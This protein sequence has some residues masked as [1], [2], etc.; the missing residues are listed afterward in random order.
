MAEQSS[1]KIVGPAVERRERSGFKE[2]GG[3]VV[4]AVKLDVIEF[5]GDAKP[6]G[7]GGGLNAAHTGHG[8]E[9]NVAKAERPADEND[10]QLDGGAKSELLGAKEIDA[11]GADVAS[12]ESDGMGFGYSSGGAKAKGKIQGSARIF[13]LLGMNTHGVGGHPGEATRKSGNGKRR[14]TQ[15]G[16]TRRFGNRLWS[17]RGFARLG[18]RFGRP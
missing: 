8:G 14:K 15:Q 12:D 5:G 4:V 1:R 2:A 11:G 16:K 9:D 3:N 7:H 10:F 13:A 17:W 18:S 6:A